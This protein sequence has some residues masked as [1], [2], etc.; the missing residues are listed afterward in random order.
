MKNPELNNQI[1]TVE[2]DTSLS[3]DLEDKKRQQ[4]ENEASLDIVIFV[5]ILCRCPPG[6]EADLV[7]GLAG[8]QVGQHNM[9]KQ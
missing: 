7:F 2:Q 9:T 4:V 8:P 3:S 1:E 5:K 6:P